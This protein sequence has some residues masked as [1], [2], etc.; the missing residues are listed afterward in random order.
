MWAQKCL[1][2][3]EPNDAKIFDIKQTK[4]SIVV[5]ILMSDMIKRYKSFL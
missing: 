1:S 3:S 5:N 2:A 4:V